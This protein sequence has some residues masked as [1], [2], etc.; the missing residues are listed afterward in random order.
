MATVFFQK[1][2][3]CESHRFVLFLLIFFVAGLLIFL[4]L[5]FVD[6]SDKKKKKSV[7]MNGT[8]KRFDSEALNEYLFIHIGVCVML[9]SR[10]F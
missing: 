6:N 10:L 5:I 9:I 4:S 8:G 1:L 7:L 2:I 3:S